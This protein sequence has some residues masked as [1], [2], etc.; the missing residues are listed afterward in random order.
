MKLEKINIKLDENTNSGLEYSLYINWINE[1]T[2][3]ITG[4][5]GVN[6]FLT[7]FIPQDLIYMIGSIEGKSYFAQYTYSN[8]HMYINNLKKYLNENF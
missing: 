1:Y 4:S 7:N 6:M 5:F 2:Y 8:Y 3:H